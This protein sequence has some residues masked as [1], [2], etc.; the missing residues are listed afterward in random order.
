[1]PEACTQ[2]GSE[3]LNLLGEWT[4]TKLAVR[5]PYCGWIQIV[6]KPETDEENDS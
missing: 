3:E 1:M 2:C 4:T 5:C 6:D